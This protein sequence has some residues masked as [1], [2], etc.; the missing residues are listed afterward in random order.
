MSI[1]YGIYVRDSSGI[2]YVN[3]NMIICYWGVEWF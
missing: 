2:I 3:V 1:I